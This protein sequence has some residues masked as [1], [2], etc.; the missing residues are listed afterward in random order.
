MG[1]LYTSIC[2]L[3]LFQQTA[4]GS[5]WKWHQ[6]A[7]KVADQ[8]PLCLEIPPSYSLL[9]PPLCKIAR[10][11]QTIRLCKTVLGACHHFV[12]F[13]I[14]WSFIVTTGSNV[15]CVTTQVTPKKLLAS[16]P[17][18]LKYIPGICH[19]LPSS[20]FAANFLTIQRCWYFVW[21]NPENWR[22]E[23]KTK[24]YVY[25]FD[26]IVCTNTFPIGLMT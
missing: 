17:F 9:L 10:N 8:L 3:T 12:C 24:L 7:E 16:F 13:H 26:F 2:L 4:L 1:R 5:G 18:A 25:S 20:P 11:L 21:V 14:L 19:S 6:A 22:V 23:E 15:K